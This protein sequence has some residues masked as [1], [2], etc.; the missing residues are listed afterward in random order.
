MEELEN[1]HREIANIPAEQ[2]SWIAS[3]CVAYDS[4]ILVE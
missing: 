3:C 4:L 2:T 1:I